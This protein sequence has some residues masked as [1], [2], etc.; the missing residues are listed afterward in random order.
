M[1]REVKELGCKIV[2]LLQNPKDLAVSLYNHTLGI[3]LFEYH[4]KWEHFLPLFLQ[5]KTEC[6]SWFDYV[7]SW[8]Q[9]ISDNPGFP[10]HLIYFEDLKQNT[11]HELYRLGQFLSIE[12]QDGLF[13]DIAKKYQFSNMVRDKQQHNGTESEFIRDGFSFFREGKQ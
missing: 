10:I 7:L 6:N 8:E 13:G 4:G 11:L 2:H 5:G 9:V 12:D 1:P 3:H